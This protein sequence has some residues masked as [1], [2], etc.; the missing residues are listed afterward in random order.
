MNYSTS[1]FLINEHVRA[2]SCIYEDERENPGQKSWT[3][4]TLDASIKVGDLVVVPSGTR[5]KM[6]VAKVVEVDADID[7]NSDIQ[8]KW[9]VQRVDRE[10]H[11]TVLKQEAEAMAFVKSADKRRHKE[12]LRVAMMKDNPE[13]YKALA[14]S[15][16]NT[17]ES[18][19]AAD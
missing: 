11:E 10:A 8:Y 14:L 5:H 12:E 3:Y 18:A 2:V 7:F 15:D 19:P 17:P 16:F 9:I 6:T 13:Q 1:V 4:K